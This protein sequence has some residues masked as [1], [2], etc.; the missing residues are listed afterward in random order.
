MAAGATYEPIATTTISGS[1]AQT[2]T[3]SSIPAT[4][5]DL[6]VILTFKAAI[7]T[8]VRMR[9]NSDTATNYST[10]YLTGNGTAAGSS[11]LTAAAQ[12]RLNGAVNTALGQWEL[13]VI[14]IF[15]YAG[16]TFK[17]CLVTSAADNNGSGGVGTT[18]G[19]WRST[20]AIN[21]ITLDSA[22][23]NQFDIGTTA[24]LYGIKAA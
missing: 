3:F 6:R 8:N 20:A 14:D 7:L 13:D 1:A 5:T 24:T 12:I 21:T 9:F 17:S 16:S 11:S 15:S 4:Y 2:I 23:V 19:L 10:T 18:V 22:Q